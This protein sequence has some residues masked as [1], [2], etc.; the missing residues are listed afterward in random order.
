MIERRRHPRY[1]ILEKLGLESH[2]VGFNSPHRLITFGLGGCGFF[3]AKAEDHLE[4]EVIE[5]Q[6]E[7]TLVLPSP[8]TIQGRLVHE[9]SVQYRPDPTVRYFGVEFQ[10]GEATLEQVRPIVEAL[11]DLEGLCRSAN[12]K[13]LV[14]LSRNF[15]LDELAAKISL[16][17]AVESN[18]QKAR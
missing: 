7:W 17:K 2:F 4:G 10:G 5:C 16:H 11:S 8:L 3:A 13:M 12:M 1:Q 6:F 9:S 18:G 15:E 14:C